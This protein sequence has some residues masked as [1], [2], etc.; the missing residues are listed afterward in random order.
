MYKAKDPVLVYKMSDTIEYNEWLLLLT[1][2]KDIKSIY[3]KMPN[4]SAFCDV[5]E[6]S[7]EYGAWVLENNILT[8]EQKSVSRDDSKYWTKI[9]YQILSCENDI[10]EI[11]EVKVHFRRKIG[12]YEQWGNFNYSDF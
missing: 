12:Y 2:N 10:F 3:K 4:I 7:L 8:L 11:K 6:Y 1:S 9:S 5:G